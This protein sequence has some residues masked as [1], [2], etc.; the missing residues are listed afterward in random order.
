MD[1][2]LGLGD[3]H[4]A[5]IVRFDQGIDVILEL[6]DVGEA[7]ARQGVALQEGEPDL[8]LV[9]PGTVG[10][11]EMETDIGIRLRRQR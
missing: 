7:G 4:G 2:G 8:D 1:D 5:D 3:R 9:E 10:R 11:R 6:L